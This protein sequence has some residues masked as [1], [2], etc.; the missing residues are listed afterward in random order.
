MALKA[1]MSIC[2][3]LV[4][5]GI[6]GEVLQHGKKSR[7]TASQAAAAVPVLNYSLDRSLCPTEPC[8]GVTSSYGPSC[9]N[10]SG[11][12]EL[13]IAPCTLSEGA[14]R[15][16][17]V[18]CQMDCGILLPQAHQAEAGLKQNWSAGFIMYIERGFLV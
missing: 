2:Y 11:K 4:P 13:L 14:S 1:M 17:T 5:L 15:K 10:P 12:R 16:F 7:G 9:C 18:V 6:L 3:D 8:E